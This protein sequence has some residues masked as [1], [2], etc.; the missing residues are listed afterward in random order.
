MPTKSSLNPSFLYVFIMKASG[1]SC[2]LLSPYSSVTWVLAITL[3]F[4]N[5]PL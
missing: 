2:R 1:S 3:V 4:V 5:P